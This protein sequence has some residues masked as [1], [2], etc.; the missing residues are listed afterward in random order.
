MASV[1]TKVMTAEEFYD[2][3]HRP[4]NRDLHF[5]LEQGEVVEMS[6]PG[7]RH[8]TVCGN[9]AFIL[10]GYIRLVKKGNVTT[11]DTGIVLG[12]DPDTVRGA[13]VALYMEKIK[14]ENLVAKYSERVPKLIVEVFSPNDR[15]G[16][17]LKRINK[18]LQKGVAMAWLVDPGE[19]TVTV[20]LP[21][22]MALVLE[23]GEEMTGQGVLPDFR[24]KAAEFF[25]TD[26]E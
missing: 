20:Y 15:H 21:D 1:L 23:G 14:F 13:D 7:E 10:G 5:E 6:R 12:R 26:G 8:G 16:K 19:E 4:E 3:M 24:C 17:M 18:F 2:F 25:V 11:N 22:Q 9:V